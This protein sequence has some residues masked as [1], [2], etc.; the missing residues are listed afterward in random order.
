MPVA[1]LG[2][3]GVLAVVRHQF[4]PV[5]KAD[6]VEGLA[7]DPALAAT[8][9]EN[10]FAQFCRLLGLTIHYEFFDELEALKAAYFHFN[11]RLAA[12]AKQTE[13][14]YA[15]LVAALGKI[16]E[17]ANFVE[18]PPEEIARAERERGEMPVEVK[19]PADAYRDV[20]MFK[21]GGHKESV[22]I[23][24]WFGFRR[25]ESE[26]EVYDDVVLVAATSA[27]P[28]ANGHL[29]RHRPRSGAVLIKH[30]H[31]I[32]SADLNT[33]LLDV[34]V[35]M[36]KRDRWTLG[37]PALIGGVPLLLKLAPTLAVLFLLAGVQLGYTGTVEQDH[38]KQA[39]AV[40]SG[41][42]A[43]GSFGAHQWLKYQRKA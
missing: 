26:V 43:L 28:A 2:F 23:S 15:E 22:E 9:D 11:P 38:M 12:S 42:I 33:L 16:L 29:R 36:N 31:D 41:V 24:E 27:S 39:L 34:Q 5:R 19:S 32:A 21:R 7:G 1:A 8:C 17:R 25:H 13:V 20:R 14:A 3:R 18:V 40:M 4:I 37:L 30:F 10:S 6:I 35:I